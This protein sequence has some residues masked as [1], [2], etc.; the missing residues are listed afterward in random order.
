[1]LLPSKRRKLP[2]CLKEGLCWQASKQAAP[3]TPHD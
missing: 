2:D 3:L 1:M